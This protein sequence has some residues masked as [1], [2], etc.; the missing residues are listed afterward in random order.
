MSTGAYERLAERGY[1]YGPAF[2]GLQAVWRRGT[3]IFAEVERPAEAGVTVGGFGIHPVVL[4]AA[5]H[6]LGVAEEVRIDRV[7]VLLA[8]GVRCMPRARRG[9][10]CGLAPVGAGAVSV[11]LADAVGLPVLSVR[12]LVTRAVSVEQLSAA[13]AAPGRVG[14]E[15]AGSGVVAGVVW[16]G[17]RRV[18]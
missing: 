14:G 13:V 6:A 10:G 9:S 1:G 4:D 2:Q 16:P 3:E 7:A 8:G 15:L 18:R 11:E 17:K 12:E 5:L